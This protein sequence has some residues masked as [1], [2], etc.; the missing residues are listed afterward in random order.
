VAALL[1]R[2]LPPRFAHIRRLRDVFPV[3]FTLADESG[4]APRPA[5]GTAV[6]TSAGGSEALTGVGGLED[7]HTTKFIC[8]VSRVQISGLQRFVSLRGTEGVCCCVEQE[9][10]EQ[11]GGRREEEEGKWKEDEEEKKEKE[12]DELEEEVQVV[13]VVCFGVLMW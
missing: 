12:E 11:V 1:A 6:P 5:A 10:E 9:Q 2:T 7:D 8:P 13:V 4:L 3:G